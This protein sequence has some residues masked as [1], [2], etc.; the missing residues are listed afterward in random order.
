MMNHL[1]ASPC[2]IGTEFFRSMFLKY[3]KE[4]NQH[5]EEM[6]GYEC[7]LYPAEE[8]KVFFGISYSRTINQLYTVFENL[9]SF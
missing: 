1:H 6:A 4:K 2:D 3:A 5:N 7:N 9:S 8:D